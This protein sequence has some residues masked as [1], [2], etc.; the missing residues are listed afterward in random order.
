MKMKPKDKTKATAEDKAKSKAKI[1]QK[2]TRK[3]E[4]IIP[5]LT[6]EIATTAMTLESALKLQIVRSN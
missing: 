4:S 6:K 5:H 1:K 3:S 2:M